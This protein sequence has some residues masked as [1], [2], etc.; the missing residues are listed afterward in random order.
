MGD[1]DVFNHEIETG[2]RVFSYGVIRWQYYQVSSAS[3]FE[4]SDACF[5]RHVAHSQ[6]EEEGF[7]GFDIPHVQYDMADPY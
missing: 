4:D 5:W 6:L 3:E 7:G 1:L 2:G